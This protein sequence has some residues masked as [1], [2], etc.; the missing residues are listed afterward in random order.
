MDDGTFELEDIAPG[1]GEPFM[2]WWKRIPE[3]NWRVSLFPSANDGWM[4]FSVIDESTPDRDHIV[5]CIVRDELEAYQLLRKAVQ[6]ERE[7]RRG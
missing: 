6:E 3:F 2:P 1:A 7:K 4:R 5:W